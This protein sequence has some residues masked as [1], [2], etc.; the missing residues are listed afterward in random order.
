MRQRV[1]ATARGLPKTMTASSAPGRWQD[2]TGR[3]L[4]SQDVVMIPTLL[5]RD[6]LDTGGFE[7]SVALAELQMRRLKNQYHY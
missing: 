4:K 2:Q 6:L 7:R 1:S 5:V 3:L